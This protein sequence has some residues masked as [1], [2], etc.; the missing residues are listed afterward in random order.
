MTLLRSVAAQ[1]ICSKR[2][3]VVTTP[4]STGFVPIIRAW[5]T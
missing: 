2:F 3:A 5:L 4:R 1:R